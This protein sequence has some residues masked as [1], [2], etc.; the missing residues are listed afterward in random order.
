MNEPERKKKRVII[1]ETDPSML[2]SLTYVL[3]DRGFVVKGTGNCREALLE[4]STGAANGEPFDLLITDIEM[5]CL[6]KTMLISKVHHAL[7]DIPAIV[8][9]G[10]G[11]REKRR[12][13][14]NLGFSDFLV[15]PF[16]PDEVVRKIEELFE[17]KRLIE[18]AG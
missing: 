2:A 4:M 13:L 8:I 18:L 17:K 15:K 9:T 3:E 6:D 1:A 5:T 16:E 10:V 12:G 14:M 7:P 11:D